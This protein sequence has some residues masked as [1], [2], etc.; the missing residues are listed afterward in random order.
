MEDD[1]IE[2]LYH[3]AKNAT[4]DTSEEDEKDT[5]ILLDYGKSPYENSKFQNLKIHGFEL[6]PKIQKLFDYALA[7]YSMIRKKD[8][9]NDVLKLWLMNVNISF[10][11]LQ[12]EIGNIQLGYF[13]AILNKHLI[14]KHINHN[15][16]GECV[17]VNR[18]TRN[19]YSIVNALK[20]R[21]RHHQ[22]MM[23]QPK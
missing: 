3:C 16:S 13:K 18:R 8:Y 21:R 17:S 20:M 5:M 14:R 11:K 23:K 4:E 22:K 6:I 12:P 2:L 9:V 15:M 1:Q 19:S 10:K 7:N